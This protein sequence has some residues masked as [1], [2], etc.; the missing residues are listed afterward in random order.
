MAKYMRSDC[1]AQ[2]IIKPT[3]MR[4]TNDA[5]FEISSSATMSGALP[6]GFR[7]DHI[8]AHLWNSFLS[9]NVP[10]RFLIIYYHQVLGSTGRKLK[11]SRPQH[12]LATRRLT[13]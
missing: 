7:R 11:D 2:S 12:S 8:S 13:G 5:H 6:P 3:G 1:A 10:K 9:I 4:S